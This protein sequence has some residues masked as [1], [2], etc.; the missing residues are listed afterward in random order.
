MAWLDLFLD[1]H[2]GFDVSVHHF[3]VSLVDAQ[4]TL[5]QPARLIDWD[6]MKA[7]VLVPAFLQDQQQL[8][9]GSCNWAPHF[10]QL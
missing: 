3:D 6:V 1:L 4:S 2:S 8:L 9:Q 5:R 7:R 10:K